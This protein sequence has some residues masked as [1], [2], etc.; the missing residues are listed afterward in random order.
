VCEGGLSALSRYLSF[1]LGTFL[2]RC[3]A[4]L[5][6]GIP[7]NGAIAPKV[8][9]YTC[10]AIMMN[11]VMPMVQPKKYLVTG[12]AGFIGSHI[13]D[14]LIDAGH[15]VVVVDNLSTGSENNLNPKAEFYEMNLLDPRLSSVFDLER[16]DIVN[17]HAAHTV[18]TRSVEDPYFDA[19]Q[20]ILG[21]L[22]LIQNCIRC[23][24]KKIVYASTGGA[25]YGEVLGI[26]PDETFPVEP[27]SP[28]GISKHTVERYLNV[29]GIQDGLN[30]MVLRYANVYGP[31]QNAHGEAG[32]VAVFSRQ[33]LAGE[34]PTIF[35]DGNK[36]RD[37]VY[38]SDVVRANLAA[39]ASD[40]SK[41][42]YNIGTGIET[43]DKEVF[44]GLAQLV[45]FAGEPNYAV[46]RRGELY[47]SVLNCRKV[48]NDLGWRAEVTLN[49]G[50]ALTFN[51]FDQLLKA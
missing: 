8:T 33:M 20:N 18:V 49:S 9:S 37:Y 4:L 10:S 38:V 29:A 46:V 42:V 35:G 16:P 25:A 30:W 41:Q 23:G 11:I 22:R 21:S 47:R 12:G 14:A 15:Q 2:G 50:L 13:V 24:V 1:D 45:G 3:I 27:I 19:E 32:V 28:Y 31:R 44:E 48:L 34:T 51:Y 40:R 36:A 5:Y 43:R 17:H 6:P 39:M 7:G 26:P